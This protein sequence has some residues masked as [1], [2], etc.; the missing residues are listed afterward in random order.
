MRRLF[1]SIKEKMEFVS[2]KVRTMR[3]FC[4]LVNATRKDPEWDSIL[5]KVK[6]E[7]DKV[8]DKPG[9]YPGLVRFLYE[10]LLIDAEE[11]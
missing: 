8:E 1:N 9:M 4:R 2:F 3:L 7:Y 11:E 6:M 10:Q 5:A